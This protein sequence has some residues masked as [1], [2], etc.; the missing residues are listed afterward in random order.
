M[1]T[2]LLSLLVFL[3][4]LEVLVAGIF[5]ARRFLQPRGPFA[6]VINGEKT[7]E[8]PEPDKL[9]A[10]LY[11]AGVFI[12]SSCGGRGTCGLCRVRVVK[13]KGA[14]TALEEE[15]LS[16]RERAEGY[17]LACMVRVNAPLSIEVPADILGARE[18]RA[19]V[20][21]IARAT[22]DIAHLSLTIPEDFRFEA[23]QYVQVR[24]PAPESPRG[25]EFRAYSVASDP[26]IPGRLELA[27]RLVPG[28]LG[29]PWLHGRRPNDELQ[30]TGPYGEWRLSPDPMRE[31]LL[32]G[33]GVGVTP[34]RSIL[35]AASRIP[36]KRVC[37]YLG[38]RTQEDLFWVEEWEAFRER[39]P[40]WRIVLA[41]SHEPP[42]SDWQGDRGFVHEAL[43][44]SWEPASG[45]LQVFVC[46][47]PA[48]TQAVL[49]V[50]EEKGVSPGDIYTDAF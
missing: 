18:V 37:F 6:I 14:C 33:G 3:I 36:G 42:G 30:L 23:G 47:P 34:L 41:L 11:A 38:V 27:V 10:Y 44:A 2:L 50:L 32:V 13:P 5:L 46:G 4:L 1:T 7:V 21:S 24:I 22:S 48:M 45:S 17:R 49:R 8:A 43:D 28:G 20:S 12:P 39:F 26:G 29:S 15:H 35:Y 9:L 40:H 19:V 16:P 25:F 31:L